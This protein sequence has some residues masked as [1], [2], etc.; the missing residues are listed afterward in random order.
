M[1]RIVSEAA[2]VARRRGEPVSLVG[3]AVRDL[4]LR[5]PVRDVDLV[6]EGETAGFA[7][8]LAERLGASV[9]VHDRFGTATLKLSDGARADV[10]S[11][12]RET[13]AYPGAL[14]AVSPGASLDEDLARRDFTIHAM[15]VELFP[16]RGLL[17][18]PFAGRR[19]L[20]ERRLRFLHPASPTD[21]PT[22][23]FR[24]VRYANRL[25]FAVAPE[26]R[27]QVAAALAIGAFDAVSGDRLRRELELVLAEPRRGR[28]VTGLIRLGL[29]RAVSPALARSAHGAARRVHAAERLAAGRDVGWL[30]AFLA[31]MGQESPR[32]LAGIA[33]RL[34]VSGR[35][36]LAIRRWGSTR[37][38]LGPGI[39]RLAPSRR[40]R[41]AEGLSPD[42]ILAAAALRSG[43][44]RRALARLAF[45]EELPITITGADL[46]ARGVPQGPGIGRALEATR[47]AR[48]DG[49]LAADEELAYALAR[50]RGRR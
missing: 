43:D 21:D 8:A 36:G 46:L 50:A 45:R 31:W 20:A 37:R 34:A 38:R 14:P 19:D 47:A 27:R 26:A 18:D 4:L 17:R 11:A 22:R 24:A 35:E 12:R 1:R 16:R 10:A 3:G 25:G 5:R 15:A 9:T 41:R 2:S 7:A 48:E 29:D 6:L 30:C 28:A 33:D 13:Y 40:R 44:D 32:A 49:R 42:E 39:A 23:A